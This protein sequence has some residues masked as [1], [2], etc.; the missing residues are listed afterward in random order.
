MNALPPYSC[1]PSAMVDQR[2]RNVPL[3]VEGDLWLRIGDQR[4]CGKSRMALLRRVAKSGSISQA[5]RELG[6]SYKNAWDSLHQMNVLAGTALT[7]RCFG[8]PSLGGGTLLTDDGKQLLDLYQQLEDEHQDFLVQLGTLAAGPRSMPTLAKPENPPAFAPSSLRASAG[9]QFFGVVV[10]MLEVGPMAE[11]TL[12]LP[13]GQQLI[14]RLVQAQVT[15]LRISLGTQVFALVKATAVRLAN[16]G[17]TSEAASPPNLMKGLVRR[18]EDSPLGETVDVELAG[19]MSITAIRARESRQFETHV[20][21]AV[22]VCF[23][24][25]AVIVVLVETA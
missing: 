25:S 6:V 24:P 5:A 16:A 2:L 21:Q 13:G 4:L 22:S 12:A 15:T 19:N 7:E 11:V 10:S 3:T 14:A 23:E 18:M 17:R 1:Q 9:N 20:G 8:G